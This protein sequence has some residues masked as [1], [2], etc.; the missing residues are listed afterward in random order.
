MFCLITVTCS[1]VRSTCTGTYWPAR[2]SLQQGQAWEWYETVS[3]SGSG[4]CGCTCTRIK[5][6]H[7]RIQTKC[8]TTATATYVAGQVAAFVHCKND[9]PVCLHVNTCTCT[10]F[11]TSKMDTEDGMSINCSSHSFLFKYGEREGDWMGANFKTLS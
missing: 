8:G 6:I 9:L 11:Y 10:N 2:P 4:I 5:S 3:V 1:Y 7:T